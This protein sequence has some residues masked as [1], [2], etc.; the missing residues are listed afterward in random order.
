MSPFEDLAAGAAP[1][2]ALLLALALI[3]EAVAGEP[4]GMLKRLPHPVRPVGA[5][6][7]FL[8]R[9]LNR[10]ERPDADRRLRG[11]LTVAIV[12]GLSGAIAYGID[13]AADR[14]PFVWL[15]EF[16]LVVALLAQRSLY[17]HVRRVAV[18]LADGL[19]AGRTAVAQIVGRDV[20]ALDGHGVARA[21]IESC[22]ENFA[23][24]VVA[25]AFWYLV[26]GLPGL[27]IYKAANTLDSMIG[28]RTA[29]H[30]AFGMV[31]ARLDDALN[32]MPARL[33][34]ALIAAAAFAVPNGRPRAAWRVMWRDADRHRS[35]NAGWPES[36][37][38]GALGLA[39]AGPRRYGETV[40]DDPWLGDGTA[41]ATAADIS[42]A[43]AVFAVACG[44][45]AW[46]VAGIV[47]IG[48]V[49]A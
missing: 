27:A 12:C 29:R 40:V 5:L 48:R 10:E 15:L 25:P 17:R 42:R 22:A 30:R 7:G 33:S 21:A 41:R 11:G 6:I 47:V 14:W 49:A 31:A 20:R 36:A 39:L 8:D 35:P 28:H 2:R 24:G 44:I 19:D 45:Q 43:L 4:R 16:A 26:A 1:E 18:A 34:G 13:G 37:M 46:L 23:D 3:V 38:A 32:L 9:R